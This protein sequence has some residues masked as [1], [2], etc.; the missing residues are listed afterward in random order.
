VKKRFFMTLAMVGIIILSACTIGTN[1]ALD[2]TRWYL[3]SL[4]D[5]PALP[6]V[7]VTIQFENGDM[8]GTDGC[9][10]YSGSYQVRDGRWRIDGE[11]TSTLMACSEPIMEQAQAYMAALRG[12]SRY[13]IEDQQLT[14][15]DASGKALLTFAAQSQ[16]LAGT[17][18]IVTNYN[19]GEQAV[20]GVLAGSQLTVEF[21][22]D[23]GLSGSAGCNRYTATYVA[24][25]QSLSI[26]PVA[27]T[28]MMCAEPAG[29]MEQEAQF[30]KALETVATYRID[31]GRLELRTAD[32][33]LALS[34]S[35]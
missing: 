35:R 26:G 27:S 2:N 5:E 18:W 9:N 33:A 4:A 29:V 8:S 1:N 11:I 16:E 12:A 34:L 31:G 32:G 13:Q 7:D 15:L 3:V 6:D 23:G 22:A 24:Q 20:V 17:S 30:L 25:E 10:W 21:D 14:L 28:R 19:N